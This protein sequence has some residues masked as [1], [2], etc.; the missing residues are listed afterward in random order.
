MEQKTLESV[1][2]AFTEYRQRKE[3][4]P[5]IF[6]VLNRSYDED[7]L[8]RLLLKCFFDDPMALV[9]V[10]RMY[11]AAFHR[12][13]IAKTGITIDSGRCEQS[14]EGLSRIDLFIQGRNDQDETFSLVIEN[15][16][17]SWEHGNQTQKYQ[18]WAEN[19]ADGDYLYFV[20]LKPSWNK[21]P[22]SSESFLPLT[23]ARLAELFTVDNPF[24]YELTHHIKQHLE[25]N[26]TMNPIIIQNSKE[27]FE[28]AKELKAKREIVAKEI[29][30]AVH[31]AFDSKNFKDNHNLPS[32]ICRYYVE[33]L[34]WR[35]DNY[36]YYF[37]IEFLLGKNRDFRDVRVQQT[38]ETFRERNSE[39]LDSFMKEKREEYNGS[40]KTPPIKK[41]GKCFWVRC[42][43]I[44]GAGDY[45]SPEW[46]A[47]IKEKILQRL[48]EAYR[49]TAKL[50]KEFREKED[51]N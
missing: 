25:V 10:L 32:G 15:K 48:D 20:F 11:D 7:L 22:L 51:L 6:S 41:D 5:T 28:M 16:T 34:H 12:D 46:C 36:K 26:E 39:K 24:I 40:S 17:R 19:N 37:Y 2:K 29:D 45:Y 42:W 50:V 47:S 23:Y 9:E 49:D 1:L 4:D 14:A 31:K 13:G 33:N 38:L 18:R 44:E 3:G 43:P 8:S 30:E 27:I 21:S 35:D